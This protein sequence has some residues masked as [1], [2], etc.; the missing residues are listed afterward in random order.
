MRLQLLQPQPSPAINV[1]IFASQQS[2]SEDPVNATLGSQVAT[3]GGYADRS[4]SPGGVTV[5][6][7]TMQPGKYLVVVSTFDPGIL[8]SFQLFVFSGVEISMQSLR[9]G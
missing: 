4:V 3:S 6:Q 1:T 7:V 2:L 9:P 8:A 5:P